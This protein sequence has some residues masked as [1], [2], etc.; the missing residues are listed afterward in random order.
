MKSFLLRAFVLF[1]AVAVFA[2]LVPLAVAQSVTQVSTTPGGLQFSVDDQVYTQTMGALWP[3]GSKH[4]LYAQPTQS[5][6]DG[7][8]QYNFSNWQWAGGTLPGGNQVIV[9]ADPSISSYQ[10][11]YSMAYAVRLIFCSCPAG[12]CSSPGTILLNGGAYKYDTL[13]YVNAGST[14][15]LQAFPSSGFVFSGWG[16]VNSGTVIQGFQQT[17]TVSEPMT[18]YPVFQEARTINFASVPNALQVLGDGAILTTPVSLQWGMGSSHTLSAVSPQQDT[19]GKFWVFGSWSDGGAFTHAYK[20]ASIVNPDTVTATFVPAALVGFFTSPQG[21]T[22]SVDGRTNW[23]SYF[24]TWGVGETHTVSAPAQQTDAQGH[25]WNFTKWSNGGSQT[26]SIAVPA[27]AAVNSISLTATYTEVGHLT[28]SSPLGGLSISVNGSQCALPCDIY[29][30][31]GSQVDVGAPA[32]VPVSPGTREDFLSWSVSGA[33]STS[34]AANGDLLVTLGADTATVTPVYH[35]MNSLTASSTPAGGATFTMQPSSPDG[36]Y[37]SQTSVT[38]TASAKPG[39]QFRAWSGDL[40]GLAA[41]GTVAMSA[42]RAVTALLDSVPY[43]LP[44]GIVNGAGLTPKA[45]VAPGSVASVYG[46]NMAPTTAI[47]PSSPMV[48]TLGGV[49]VSIGSQMLPLYFVSPAQINFQLP[50]GLAPGAQTLIVSAP[51]QP[52]AQAVFQVAADAPGVFELSVINGVTLGLLT[53]ADGSLVTSAAPSLAGETLSLYGTGFGP[54]LPARPEGLAV[55]AS[56]PY[57]LTDP[58]TIQL[59]SVSVAPSRAYAWPGAVGVDV[60]QF[61]VPGG[62]PSAANAPLTV[63]INGTASNTVQLPI[64]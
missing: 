48:Q 15:V 11:I 64:H 25:L 3:A 49:T 59:G 35:L 6:A 39:F 51:G 23:P 26:Q 12:N 63:T 37:D 44:I 57:V 46:A 33:A 18:F 24:F 29:Q 13:I 4:T 47:G 56:P 28:V 20:V 41:T 7:D 42:P 22:L 38:V 36:Y 54:T 40:T 27:S 10:A 62:L 31:L 61:V 34:T 16:S 17:I 1:L 43:I 60:I 50:L 32:S 5:T 2:P 8:V 45:V 52:N 14:A 19:S 55:P 58:A 30:P 21:L 53:H 9:T